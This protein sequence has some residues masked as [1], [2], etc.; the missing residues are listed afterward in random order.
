MALMIG[1][2]ILGFAAGRCR[3]LP[4]FLRSKV[5]A[6]GSLALIVLLFTLGLSMGSDEQIIAAL[7]VLGLKAV[8]LAVGTV[9]GSVLLVWSAT[10]LG[11]RRR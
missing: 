1:A 7:P 3:L 6:M 5:S 10:R 9:M 8:L 11:G 4:D 2:L